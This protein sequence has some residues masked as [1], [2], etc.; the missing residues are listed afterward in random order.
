MIRF[1]N[2]K[3]ITLLGPTQFATDAA[4]ATASLIGAD[5]G[6]VTITISKAKNTSAVTT[7]PTIQILHSDNTSS[8]STSNALLATTAYA[9]NT[10]SER[11]IR[12]L[13]STKTI[14]KAIKI[15]ATPETTTNGNI[16]IAATLRLD[17]LEESP[18]STS[19]MVGSTHDAVVI[20]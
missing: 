17:R 20:S 8:F 16:S 4:S 11:T 18:G 9:A 14:G 13:F 5:S 6:E 10:S 15:T 3:T 7:T 19:E 1:Q 12:V 2:Q